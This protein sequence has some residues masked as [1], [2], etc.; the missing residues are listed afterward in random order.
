M[1]NSKL[2]GNSTGNVQQ[3]ELMGWMVGLLVAAHFVTSLPFLSLKLSYRPVS[4]DSCG[5]SNILACDEK[6]CMCL[7]L[8]S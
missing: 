7:S 8:L 6:F 5:A 3:G 2:K 4:T 1:E